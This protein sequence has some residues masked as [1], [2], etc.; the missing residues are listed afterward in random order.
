MLIFGTLGV[1][2]VGAELDLQPVGAAAAHRDLPS[3]DPPATLDRQRDAL[4]GDDLAEA[5]IALEQGDRRRVDLG[6]T[7]A[8]GAASAASPHLGSDGGSGLQVIGAIIGY[9]LTLAAPGPGSLGGPACSSSMS[10][11]PT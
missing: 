1:E 10:R 11:C 9:L 4:P 2:L 5:T 8:A 3:P 6:L 7:D